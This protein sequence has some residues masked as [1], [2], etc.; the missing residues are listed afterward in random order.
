[1]GVRR[2]L[3]GGDRLDWPAE[4]SVIA[5]KGVSLGRPTST[6]EI[7]TDQHERRFYQNPTALDAVTQ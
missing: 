6:T 2:V 7:T 3:P 4:I 1:M 5:P